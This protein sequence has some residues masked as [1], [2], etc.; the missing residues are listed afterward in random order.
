M[1]MPGGGRPKGHCT[2]GGTGLGLCTERWSLCGVVQCIMGDGYMRSS[3]DSQT[4]MT[5]NITFSQAL[6]LS[7]RSCL[8]NW[9]FRKWHSNVTLTILPQGKGKKS[10]V[11]NSVIIFI[12]Y[13]KVTRKASNLWAFIVILYT[14]TGWLSTVDCTQIYSTHP[15]MTLTSTTSKTP[16]KNYRTEV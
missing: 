2:R 13:A 16:K 11:F 5:E 7:Y 12:V 8:V 4:D 6:C 10:L 15:R 14:L 1:S 9:T 3:V